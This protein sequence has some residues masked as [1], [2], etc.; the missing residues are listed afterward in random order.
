MQAYSNPDIYE[1][2]V[3]FV[4][5][6]DAHKAFMDHR[7]GRASERVITLLPADTWRLPRWGYITKPII[8]LAMIIPNIVLVMHKQQPFIHKMS[9][10]R[11][12]ILRLF[13]LFLTEARDYLRGLEVD[14]KLDRPIDADDD[15]NGAAA[16]AAALAEDE[17]AL[18]ANQ[19][20]E[21]ARSSAQANQI[22]EI[23]PIDM[24]TIL[25][26]DDCITIPEFE[27]RFA[28]TL[29]KYAPATMGLLKLRKFRIDKEMLIKFAPFLMQLKDFRIHTEC[30]CYMLYVMHT[31]CPQLE[32]FGLT[33]IGWEGEFDHT[34]IQR[35]PSLRELYIKIK[36]MD[37]PLLCVEG[38]RKLQQFIKE[39]PQ[40]IT[41]QI[42]SVTDSPLL[43][44]ICTVLKNLES[45]TLVRENLIGLNDVLDNLFTLKQMSGMKLTVVDVRKSDLNAVLKCLKRLNRL[46]RL[47]MTAICIN[48][49]PDTDATENDNDNDKADDGDDADDYNGNPIIDMSYFERFRSFQ[50]N[51][52]EYDHCQSGRVISTD[53]KT[54]KVPKDHPAV[55]IMVNTI[56]PVGPIGRAI[57][58]QVKQLFKSSEKYFPNTIEQMQIPKPSSC[59]YVHIGSK[60]K[61]DSEK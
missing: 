19:A 46:P 15:D 61:L 32:S 39:N 43:T 2:Y 31:Y 10:T 26:E 12:T 16:A 47:K 6:T 54:V 27:K 5:S 42:D 45:I 41:L 3:R 8:E 59:L 57:Y 58:K 25:Q 48:C 56:P 51:N 52:H 44:T 23:V 34:P 20:N 36:D 17:D 22:A 38:N 60:G 29:I 24:F 11:R 30:N 49:V 50:V 1:A 9:V 37:D 35:W 33:G 13:R 7:S 14:Y 40:L 55:V 28:E 4:N 53:G 21:Q 18:N